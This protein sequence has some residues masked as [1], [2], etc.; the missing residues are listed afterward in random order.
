MYKYYLYRHI[1]LDKNEPFYIGIGSQEECLYE[2]ARTRSGRPIEWKDIVNITK[3]D[4]DILLESYDKKFILEREREFIKL[5][6]RK[7]LGLGTLVNL[8]DGGEGSYN[9][10]E[11]TRDKIRNALT[12]IKRSAETKNKVRLANLGKKKAPCS[13]ET[14]RKIGDKNRGYNNGMFGK[15]GADHPNSKAIIQMT[16]DGTYISEFVNARI[17]MELTNIPYKDISAAITG[18]QKSAGGYKWKFV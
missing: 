5:Y 16:L 7:N 12:G 17:A 14:K 6:G 15:Y 9:P 13:Q 18:R 3:Y 8:T 1:R 2:R 11:E 10:S 4:I